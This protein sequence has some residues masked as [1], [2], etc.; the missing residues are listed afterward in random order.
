MPQ[1]QYNQINFQKISE[2]TA[3]V[4]YGIYAQLTAVDP[5]YSEDVNIP[6]FAYDENKKTYKVT[7]ISSDAFY[8]HK[9]IHKIFIPD[10]IE[11][12]G[13]SSLSFPSLQKIIFAPNSHLREMG[14]I[15]FI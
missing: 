12:I 2:S 10:S 6:N 11:I 4:G 15:L 13:W 1:F 8:Y 3:Q 14:L 9:F 5:S 7:I